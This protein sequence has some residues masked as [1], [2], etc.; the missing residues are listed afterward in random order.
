MHRPLLLIIAIAPVFAPMHFA[1]AQRAPDSLELGFRNPPSSA[2]PH[3][4]WHWTMSNVT[5]EGI[6]KDL[7]WMKR[8]G[9]AGMQLADVNAGAGQTV[10]HKIV[11]GTP[12]WLDAV[13]HAAAESDRLGL[14]MDIFASPGWSLTGGPWV[15]P[16]QAMKKLVW[17][18][19]SVEGPKHVR[20]AL[21]H[22][23]SNNGPI[24]NLGR[25]GAA[26][27][28]P[29]FYGDDAVIAYR[30]PADERTMTDAHPVVTT[31]A[32]A[33][34]AAPL[35]DDDL[36][37]ALTV[38]APAGGPAW[39]QLTFAQPYRARAVS[40]A[41][42][43][44]IPFGRVLA[45]D[46]GV[47]FRALVAL[48]GAQQY[49]PSGVRTYDFPETSARIYRLE[50]TGAPPSP[51]AVMSQAPAQPARE[52]AITELVLHGGGRVHRWEE[53]AGF[54]F[55]FE[56]ES[57]ATPALPSSA[58]IPRAGVVDLTRSMAAD[59]TL[60]W[61]VPPGRWT[62]LRMGRSLTG[63]KNRPAVPA[64]SG[65][66]VDKLSRTHVQAYLRDYTAPIAAALG[67]LYGKSLTHVLLDSWEAGIQNWTDSMVTQFRARRGYDP[68][69]YLPALAGRVVE[70]AEV[71]DRF[72]WDFRRTLVD[73]FAENHYG[74]AAEFFRKQGLGTYSEASG[75]SLEPLEDALLNK[76]QVDIPMGEFWFRSL[77]PWAMYY[78]DVRGTASASHVYG[79]PLV[80]AESFTGGGYESPYS[81][82][83]IGDYWLAQGINRL[84][85]HTSAHQPLDTKPGNTMVG[86]HINRNITWAEQ[87]APF[88]T[89]L[90]RSSYLLQQG[91]FVADL[92]YL[93]NEGAPSTMPFWGAGLQPAPPPGYDYDYVNAD[94]LL[95]RMSVSADGRLVLPDGMSY[96][97]LV[98]PPIDRMTLPVLRKIG[99]LA[100]GG[101][102]IVGP[103]PVKSPSL[104]GYP[105]A[106][107]ELTALAQ[108]IWGDLD[109]VS[110]TKREYGKG[111]VVW[112]QSLA[113]VLTGGRIAAD[114]EYD[115]VLDGELAWLHRRT[116]DADLY[117]LTGSWDRPRELD[118]R[119][120]VSG[121]EPEIWHP[122]T[123]AI[124]PASYEIVGDRTTVHLRTTERDA[125]FVVFRRPATAPA[126]ALPRETRTTLSTVPG[127]WLVRFP[128]GFGAPPSIT[129][130]TLGSWT[131]HP[132]SGVKFFSGTASYSR[133]VNAPA[134]WFGQGRRLLLELGTV[135]DLAEVVVNGQ[136][137]PLLW[138]APYSV[139]VSR[140]LRP[141]ANRVEIRVTNEWTNRLTGDRLA[142]AGKK[143][144]GGDVPT[145]TFGPTPALVESGLLGPVTI[146]SVITH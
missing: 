102:T 85:F 80:A 11:F 125:L 97:L 143:V 23:P 27:Q 64:A 107:T 144:L 33:A 5:K 45:S 139:D 113:D 76:K 86:T 94:A 95:T 104:V 81:L 38:P 49:R 44:S 7:E 32:G 145:R 79:K 103:R 111:T 66:E 88:M 100:R 89:Y 10:E 31:H 129:L 72:L 20:M 14:E 116:G 132:D 146:T 25:G 61:D 110:R 131:T 108:E 138:K 9:I 2:R 122:D 18:E 69:P 35:F 127:P 77:H 51:A 101:A 57:S 71:S 30:T 1:G 36:N 17:S 96:R 121:K 119:F 55:L 112:G 82:K 13:R 123:G 67:P 98:L 120:R 53:K 22:P 3:T 134:S 109:G 16:A 74:T 42:R 46:D 50:L 136:T 124:E 39:I 114:V 105:A 62:V 115:R 73:M 59:G 29:T 141:G 21:P 41:S 133:T 126:R 12:E 43:G 68:T 34:D 130:A 137:L 65:Y 128:A 40:L 106:D 70:S 87:A 63:A 140:S 75:V 83:K 54:N 56:Y 142:P 99:E 15:T 26:T 93:L 4:W 37:T 117:Y 48:P 24:R 91:K 19:T 118:V 78:A 6:T 47:T 90:A 84:V 8:V 28:D 52:Y 60:D 92:A 135:R 58:T